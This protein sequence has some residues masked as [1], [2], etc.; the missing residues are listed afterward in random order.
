MAVQIYEFI[1][2]TKQ[3]YEKKCIIGHFFLFL[4]HFWDKIQFFHLINV[5]GF[6]ENGGSGDAALKQINQ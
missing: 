3:K 2:K 1:S 5:G 6:G 4:D